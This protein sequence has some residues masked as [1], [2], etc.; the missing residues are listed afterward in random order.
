MGLVNTNVYHRPA[1]RFDHT[2]DGLSFAHHEAKL[3]R[4]HHSI[5]ERASCPLSP[6]LKSDGA[7][8]Q[9]ALRVFSFLTEL[10]LI[11]PPSTA[12]FASTRVTQPPAASVVIRSFASR[13]MAHGTGNLHRS[14]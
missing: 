4:F 6:S 5:P 11:T 1:E 2:G 7:F 9:S 12:R 13:N 3:D 14:S 8:D 10:L